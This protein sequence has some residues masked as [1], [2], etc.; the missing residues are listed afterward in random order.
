MKKT[1]TLSYLLF[2]SYCFSVAQSIDSLSGP[3]VWLNAD[4]SELTPTGWADL[5]VFDND[6][7]AVSSTGAPSSYNAINFNR[8]LV[9]DGIDD[10]LKIPYSLGGLSEL[11]IL[12]V[13]QSSDTTER[14][15]W[16][17]DESS[18]KVLLTTRRVIGPDTIADA[19]GKNESITVLNSVMQNWDDAGVSVSDGFMA[20]GS[21]GKSAAFKPFKGSIAE[22]L[23][24][25]HALTFL[26]RVQFETYLAIKY[27]TGLRGGNFVSSGEKVLWHVAQNATYGR[28]IAGIGRDDKFKLY[29]K[30]SGSAYDSGLLVLNAGTLAAS[31]T[32]NLSTINNQDFI[33]WGDNGLPLSTQPGE[34]PDSLLS[35]VQRKWLVT[36]T[37]NTAN[38]LATELYID[39]NELPAEPMR[40][41]LVID[42]SARGD[43]SADNLEYILPDRVADGKIV[44][45]NVL[46]DQDGSG[47]DNFG[48]ARAKNLFAAVRT[49]NSPSCTDEMAG[50]IRIDVIAGTAAYN[51]TLNGAEG[52]ISREWRQKTEMVEQNDLVGGR[53]TLTLK[54]DSNETL[55]RH[56]TLTVP[57]ALDIS[58][59]PDQALSLT[60]PV[61]LQ[62]SGQV[63]DSVAVSYRWENSFGFSSTEKAITAR[64]AG[65]YRVFVTKEKDG[66]VFTDDIAIT[67]GEAQN[68]A[69]Y[70]TILSSNENYNVSVSLEKPASVIVKVYNAN[71]IM[72][73]EMQ[74]T[75]HS[76]YQFITRIKDSGLFLVVIQTPAGMETRKIIVH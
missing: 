48:F 15:I 3:R 51:F 37:G 65:I 2:A 17:A 49:L 56:F 41:W 60:E 32:E 74:G 40:Y 73:D 1:L 24:F 28:H 25:D 59:G 23:V 57:D 12:A 19:Y 29:Q 66:C 58:L 61:V 70:P 9:F 10:Y 52:A 50:R 26:E 16:G 69:V 18:R 38:K 46:W 67:G 44:Y 68:I 31:N 6:A 39:V 71:G 27:G 21:A 14:G 54:D 53:Y 72:I 30:Q 20:L 64:E 42:R 36:V 43:F 62:V 35:I 7:I 4:R 75:D 5:S 34:G 33:L 55:T 63:P 45:K 11:S 8:S 22:L 76:E 13:Y 47:K